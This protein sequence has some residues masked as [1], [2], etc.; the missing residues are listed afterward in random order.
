MRKSRYPWREWTDGSPRVIWYPRHFQAST[1]GMRST[2]TTH[3]QKRDMAVAIVMHPMH[4]HAPE[5][6]SLAF[7]FFPDRNY[8]DGP[9]DDLFA[10]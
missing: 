5:D 10:A 9:P 3:A 4:P 2:I 8:A 6:V 7:Q 1:A